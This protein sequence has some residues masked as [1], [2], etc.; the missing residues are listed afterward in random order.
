MHALVKAKSSQHQLS[1]ISCMP[2]LKDASFWDIQV[3]T[4]AATYIQIHLNKFAYEK[5]CS[6]DLHVVQSGNRFEIHANIN[7]HPSMSVSDVLYCQN[8][9]ESAYYSLNCTLNEMI[10]QVK[11]A[12]FHIAQR[13]ALDKDDVEAFLGQLDQ[14][15]DHLAKMPILPLVFELEE[16]GRA[17]FRKHVSMNHTDYISETTFELASNNEHYKFRFNFYSERDEVLKMLVRGGYA[18]TLDFETNHPE[19]FAELK[20]A[21][22]LGLTGRMY[23]IAARVG[24]TLIGAPQFKHTETP[25]KFYSQRF[26]NYSVDILEKGKQRTL[27]TK[28][29]HVSVDMLTSLKSDYHTLQTRVEQCSK[30]LMDRL[31]KASLKEDCTYISSQ[32]KAHKKVIST[33]FKSQFT[34]IN[35]CIE[36]LRRLNPTDEG[37]K[38]SE[39]QSLRL[40]VVIKIRADGSLNLSIKNEDGLQVESEQVALL[41]KSLKVR[42]VLLNG[43]NREEVAFLISKQLNGQYGMSWIIIN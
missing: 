9:I 26:L 2:E 43:L 31:V 15:S 3:W 39:D 10:T 32:L 19:V 27:S 14:A 13:H 12:G 7:I 25:L 1:K 35:F 18:L 37:I 36:N 21:A 40:N 5:K 24:Y 17:F 38:V 23:E 33:A 30:R 11:F 8:N 6:N 16:P 22:A 4:K 41:K 28:K 34:E 29:G 42:A 20:T